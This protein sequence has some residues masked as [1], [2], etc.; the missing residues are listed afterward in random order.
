VEHGLLDEAS[1]ARAQAEAG[2]RS[3][4]E[5][6]VAEGLVPRYAVDTLLAVGGG[7]MT[8]LASAG[9]GSETSAT[10]SGSLAGW[11]S[12][13]FAPS[14]DG[15]VQPAVQASGGPALNQTLGPYLILSELGR[16]GGGRVYRAWDPRHEREVALKVLHYVDPF[17][18]KRFEREV[19]AVRRL[20]H[21]QI[22][23]LLDT[24]EDGDRPYMVME[25]VHGLT[26]ARAEELALTPQHAVSV[27]RDAARAIHY[28]HQQGVVHRDLKP[29][30]V[31]VD[32]HGRGRVLDFGLARL[33]D[34][35]T[36]LT[37]S[38]AL[39]GTLPFM[40][41]EQAR[42]PAE[43][44]APTVDVYALGAT[45]YYSLTRTPPLGP[46]GHLLPEMPDPTLPSVKVP[47]LSPELDAIVMTCLER[48]PQHRY[49]TAGD[50]ADDLDRFLRG[51][52]LE[53]RRRGGLARTWGRARRSP[54]ALALAVCLPVLAA[55][56][57][58]RALRATRPP[59]EPSPPAEVAE[60]PPAPPV[61]P[62]VDAVAAVIA[63]LEQASLA[64]EVCD[65]Q[66]LADD[67]ARY[68]EV[69]QVAKLL[70]ARLD[71]LSDELRRARRDLLLTV[72]QPDEREQARGDPP[73]D[74]LAEAI[75]A[76]DA[77]DEDEGEL[78][79]VHA[80]VLGLAG[81]RLTS[82]ANRGRSNGAP[83]T[84]LDLIAD[85]QER[86]LGSTG[87]LLAR[88]VCAALGRS[89]QRRDSVAA[90]GRYLALE[91]DEARAVV[92]GLALCRLGGPVALDLVLQALSRFGPQSH[93]ANAVGSELAAHGEPLAIEARASLELLAR[94][95][96]RAAVGDTAGALAD[97][98]RAAEQDPEL[99]TAWNRVGVA[100]GRLGRTEEAREAYEQALE[101]DPQASAARINLARLRAAG[102]DQRG[103]IADLR[104]VLTQT[105]DHSGA[106][107]ALGLM[108]HETGQLEMALESY[109]RAL[110]LDRSDAAV[111]NNRATTHRA[112]GHYA[113]AL[114]DLSASLELDPTNAVVWA[115]RADLRC[116]QGRLRASQTDYRRALELDPRCVLALIV[117]AEVRRQRGNLAG[118]RRSA[119]EAISLDPT[120]APG[121]AV[122][123]A[124][125][126]GQGDLPGAMSDV[127]R[128]LE[129]DPG[130]AT[131]WVNRGAIHL[132][133]DDVVAGEADFSRALDLDPRDPQMWSN[134]AGARLRLGRDAEAERD[135]TRAL[136]LDPACVSAWF[137]RS[138]ARQA[139]GRLDEA[140]GDLRRLLDLEP[141]NPGAWVNLGKLHQLRGEVAEAVAA[142]SHVIEL[143]P[144][145]ARAWSN[146]GALR[147]QQGDV[148]GAHDDTSQ[149]L[150]LDPSLPEAWANRS[151]ANKRQGRLDDALRDVSRALELAPGHANYHSNRAIVHIELEDLPAALADLDRA[152][153]LEPGAARHWAN[154]GRVRAQAGLLD[155][156]VADLTEALR[157][158]P[159]QVGLLID[160][161]RIREALGDIDGAAADLERLLELAP[162]HE[163]A[164]LARS[165]LERLRPQE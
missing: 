27:V 88:A 132:A 156:A 137:N 20:R 151:L 138:L 100:L 116:H 19:S 1:L 98:R 65:P 109:D 130:S 99:A 157:L 140:V 25:L 10:A 162:D 78:A 13:I 3:L 120:F 107:A 50:L 143:E 101:V 59:L 134:R 146:R 150:R 46:Q 7:G 33:H 113:W 161:A 129:H 85:E 2:P 82:R 22:V 145:H 29:A 79:A 96:L 60:R 16:G 38:D 12:E 110:E 123:A 83:R 36:P 53:V 86:A 28:A 32:E 49:Q 155:G 11:P 39:V 23:P 5:V 121:W 80:D 35:N 94:G 56:L 128:G 74:G 160:T 42:C 67:L 66:V 112:L 61:A 84:A 62:G 118:A 69:P 31:I 126:L 124:I 108:F 18:R 40:P 164:P 70:C 102:G 30:N 119:D 158:D 64:P 72:E 125:R 73:L 111:F 4:A 90:L 106:W 89:E 133:Q 48:A 41:P 15:G 54:A 9:P 135:A 131:L 95:D 71:A 91:A 92:A 97:Y 122:R 58:L 26:L 68:A 136:E 55:L 37:A 117:R 45:L 163:L 24:G 63:A 147:Y 76:W 6:V 142:F 14:A 104:L 141:E 87:R 21:P 114:D 47:G 115:N 139:L 165:R 127:E 148:Q 153:D 52:P 44:L 154:R 43:A 81:R 93:F 51:Q 159:S 75:D 77:L 8:N 144:R 103:A 152:L 105:P 57:G 149:A 34:Q 17:H